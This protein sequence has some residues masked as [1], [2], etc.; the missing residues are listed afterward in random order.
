MP[1][2]SRPALARWHLARDD[3]AIGLGEAAVQAVEEVGPFQAEAAHKREQG[4]QGRPV[5]LTRADQLQQQVHRG[6]LGVVEVAGQGAFADEVVEQVEQLF[7]AG[8]VAFGLDFKVSI[9]L[10]MKLR[11]SLFKPP[12]DV[13]ALVMKRSRASLAA[14]A[15]VLAGSEFNAL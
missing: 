8:E 15:G 12:P 14:L 3:G 13:C 4:R 10:S 9:R 1:V 11:S 5:P 2:P 6:E 7:E